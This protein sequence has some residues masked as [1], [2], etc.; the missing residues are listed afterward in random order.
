MVRKGDGEVGVKI[1]RLWIFLP[2]SVAT[3]FF[4]D[5]FIIKL[6]NSCPNLFFYTRSF[7]PSRMLESNLSELSEKHSLIIIAYVNISTRK[8]F[9][10]SISDKSHT[11]FCSSGV[12]H[13]N[14]CCYLL[15]Q[16]TFTT[17]PRGFCSL[18]GSGE[19]VKRARDQNHLPSRVFL[20]SL[21]CKFLEVIYLGLLFRQRSPMVCFP[22]GDVLRYYELSF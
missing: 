22:L 2:L 21:L 15:C 20:L 1:S 19:F 7:P 18:V 14:E 16:L 3:Q 6:S 9:Q 8:H 5:N 13:K 11:T 17:R 10:D 4:S 12:T